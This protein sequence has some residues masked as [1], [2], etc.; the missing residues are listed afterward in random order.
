[1][2]EAGNLQRRVDNISKM[3]DS[4][5]LEDALRAGGFDVHDEEVEIEAF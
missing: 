2:K 1:M 3:M 4:K 5:M